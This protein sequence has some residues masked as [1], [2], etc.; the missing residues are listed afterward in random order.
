M[1]GNNF[2]IEQYGVTE[3]SKSEGQA[4]NGGVAGDY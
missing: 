1:K 4:I 2:T 3:L